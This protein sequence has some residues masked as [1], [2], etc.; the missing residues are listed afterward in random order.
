MK[1][2]LC[3]ILSILMLVPF[4]TAALTMS[5]GAVDEIRDEDSSNTSRAEASVENVDGATITGKVN[6][7]FTFDN[8]GVVILKQGQTA[9]KSVNITADGNYYLNDIPA[10]TYTLI[11][12]IPGWTEYT[13]RDVA[14]HPGE[15]ITIYFN[16]VIPGDVDHSGTIDI[17][18]IGEAITTIGDA[19]SSENIGAD[20]DHDKVL[21]LS[22]LSIVLAEKNY[23]KSGYSISYL[24]NG[25]SNIY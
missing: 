22:D 10:G 21:G 4:G 11:V 15:N 19:L 24:N 14:A 7:S 3:V 6:V 20:V 1:K 25:W 9:V 13:V 2:L 12:S 5:A 17:T 8:D 16:T 18:D 23:G